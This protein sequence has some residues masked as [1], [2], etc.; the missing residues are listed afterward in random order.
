VLYPTGGGE[1]VT[2]PIAGLADVEWEA[3]LDAARVTAEWKTC[4]PRNIDCGA[5]PIDE[6]PL[7]G[8]AKQEEMF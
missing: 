6:S 8:G 4:N 5:M 1:I 2:P 7:F 3:K